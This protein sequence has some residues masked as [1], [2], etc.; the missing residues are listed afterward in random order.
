MLP[1]PLKRMK[2]LFVDLA[3]QHT[4]IEKALARR[5]E[6]VFSHSSFIGGE[7]VKIFEDNFA[8]YLGS[9]F[10][11]GV[12]NGTDAIFLSLRALDIEPGDEVIMIP[13]TF[14]AT[15]SAI[16]HAGGTP[17]FV[18]IDPETRNFDISSLESRIGPHT[19]AIIPVHLYG[20]PADMDAVLGIARAHDLKV[21]EDACQAHG[22]EYRGKKVGTFGDFGCFSFYPG[23]NL[24]AYGDAGMIV[25]DNEDLAVK[26]RKLR[27]HGGIGKYEHEIL[28][29]NS[30]LDSLQAAVLDE[31]LK[32]LDEWNH[33]RVRIARMY[34]EGLR[35]IKEIAVFL[36]SA[37]TS[38][39]YHLYVIKLRSGDRRDFIRYMKD[40]GIAT[41]IHYPEPV[42]LLPPFL[43]LGYKKGD[44]PAA[45]EYMRSIVSLPIFPGMTEEQ[46]E[47][48][49]K[50]V[51]EYFAV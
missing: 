49:I 41:G 51:N 37:D 40:C 29:Y 2:I 46:A 36:S 26:T 35:G 8:R 45:E 7:D 34:D 1:E 14:V 12:A 30:R 17:V 16:V 15:A 50:A 44:F 13:T 25:T 38:P 22:A 28:G 6:R 27:N 47:Y 11:V 33:M 42:H 31:K 39:V 18:D 48:V 3:W 10:A 9:R 21:V 4:I 19:K 23:K 32:F 5:F 43:D 24:G 20:Q